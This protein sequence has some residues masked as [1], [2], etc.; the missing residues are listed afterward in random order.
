MASLVYDQYKDN[1]S[2]FIQNL[3]ETRINLVYRGKNASDVFLQTKFRVLKM[4][5]GTWYTIL[6]RQIKTQTNYCYA[7]STS[8]MLI[9]FNNLKVS[10]QHPI[11]FS[12]TLTNTNTSKKAYIGNHIDFS[13]NVDVG[14]IYFKTHYTKYTIIQSPTNILL[15]RDASIQCNFMLNT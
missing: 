9:N 15:D 8:S 11:E 4:P 13:V 6:A 10:Q 1:M 3:P 2:K 7:Y 12:V 14:K 5:S